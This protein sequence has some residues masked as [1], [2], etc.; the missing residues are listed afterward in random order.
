MDESVDAVV[1]KSRQAAAAIDNNS[2]NSGNT[3]KFVLNYFSD[4]HA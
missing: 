1:T 4:L 2:F 3:D